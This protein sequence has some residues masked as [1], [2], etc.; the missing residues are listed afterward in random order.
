[1]QLPAFPYY[2]KGLPLLKKGL[3]QDFLFASDLMLEATRERKP[4]V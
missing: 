4:Y 1:M 2:I 3:I